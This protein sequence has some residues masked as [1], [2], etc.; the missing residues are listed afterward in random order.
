MLLPIILLVVGYTNEGTV[1]KQTGRQACVALLTA[2]ETILI[3]S[4]STL[5]EI[6]ITGVFFIQE[7]M[8]DNSELFDRAW[9][10]QIDNPF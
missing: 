7:S 10:W 8:S 9:Q 4:C 1:V 6:A 5:A 3:P 2:S